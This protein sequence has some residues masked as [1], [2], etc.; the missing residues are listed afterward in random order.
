MQNWKT[1]FVIYFACGAMVIF[2]IL[3][4]R[5]LEKDDLST[6]EFFEHDKSYIQEVLD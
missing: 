2:F 4:V 3:V 6:E 5:A 1:K